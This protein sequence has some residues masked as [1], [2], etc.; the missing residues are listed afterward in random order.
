M[1]SQEQDDIL[2][3]DREMCG[4]AGAGKLVTLDSPA[5]WTPERV[6]QWVTE[7]DIPLDSVKLLAEGVNGELLLELDDDML[8]ELGVRAATC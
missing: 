1:G 4:G 6:C 2:R 3:Y 5:N 7:E 8:T